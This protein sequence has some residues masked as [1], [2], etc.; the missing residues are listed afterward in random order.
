MRKSLLQLLQI[1]GEFGGAVPTRQL[2]VYE[3]VGHRIALPCEEQGLVLHHGVLHYDEAGRRHADADA[4]EVVDG[5][6]LAID[7][8]HRDGIAHAEVPLAVA[9]DAEALHHLG[10]GIG[11]GGLED[12]VD[13]LVATEVTGEGFLRGGDRRTWGRNLVGLGVGR[14]ESEK[15]NS[16]GSGYEQPVEHCHFEEL[17]L[18]LCSVCELFP[19]EW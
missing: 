1:A 11:A 16:G 4:V 7:L 15:R 3:I 13:H 10:V 2:A 19:P 14:A 8:R 12:Q 18:S 5:G 6:D 9:P 17:P